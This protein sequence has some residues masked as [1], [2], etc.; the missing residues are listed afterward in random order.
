MY[1]ACGGGGQSGAGQADCP[2]SAACRVYREKELSGRE[3][4]GRPCFDRDDRAYPS[5]G[6]VRQSEGEPVKHQSVEVYIKTDKHLFPE[7]KSPPD[8]DFDNRAQRQRF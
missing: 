6:D 4:S 3:G 5:G 1:P 2:Q 7:K 8:R